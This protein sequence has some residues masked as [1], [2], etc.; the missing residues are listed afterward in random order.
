VHHEREP[1]PAHPLP[2]GDPGQTRALLIEAAA[3]VFA[4][5]GLAS[6]TAEDVAAA[7]G[8]PVQAV[9]AQFATPEQLLVEVMTGQAE[10]RIAEATWLVESSPTNRAEAAAALSRLLI[11]VA[12]KDAETAPLRAELWSHALRHPEVMD[13]LAGQA[14]TF[15]GLLAEII[16]ARFARLDPGF[17]VP[18]EPLAT[19]M[20]ALFDGLVQRRRT[21]PDAVPE[22]LFGQALQWLIIGVRVAGA[23]PGGPAPA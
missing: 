6:T 10:E 21:D 16:K 20:S 4:A 2:A 13:R 3:G 18:V 1:R 9:Y 14:R 11:A 7:A 8:L 5:K 22:E 12:D 17:D 23:G 15:D 19:A